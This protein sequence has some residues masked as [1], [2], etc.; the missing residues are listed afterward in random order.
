MPIFRRRRFN[1]R[2]P[3]RTLRMRRR[4]AR[5]SR[6]LNQKYNGF[7][8]RKIDEVISMT[9][10]ADVSIATVNFH[11]G[12]AADAR[13]TD[14][15]EWT[16]TNSFFAEYRVIGCKMSLI[17]SRSTVTGDSFNGAFT[18]IS[19]DRVISGSVSLVDM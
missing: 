10:T 2:R 14:S 9:T 8:C 7:A 19:Y 15:V 6:P 1:R 5:P 13:F 11:N 18:A 12:V 16:N 4:R 3:R 17:F